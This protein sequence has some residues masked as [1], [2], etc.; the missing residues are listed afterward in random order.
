M[1]D[2]K[3]E[4]QGDKEKERCAKEEREEMGKD[5]DMKIEKERG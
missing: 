2:A 1:E 5:K 3:E 4:M